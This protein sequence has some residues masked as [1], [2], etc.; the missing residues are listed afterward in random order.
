M[1]L[2]I[3]NML[4][5]L[6]LVVVLGCH[7][8]PPAPDD[9][10][11]YGY[12]TILVTD[13]SDYAVT[14]ARVQ[15]RKIGMVWYIGDTTNPWGLTH[16]Y[17][18]SGDTTTG[19]EVDTRKPGYVPQMDTFYL[20]RT[21]PQLMHVVLPEESGYAE[22]TLTFH[23]CDTT[24]NGVPLASLTS[25][26]YPGPNWPS[27]WVLSNDADS[28]GTILNNIYIIDTAR[29]FIIASAW[30]AGYE[31]FNETFWLS[32]SSSQEIYITLKTK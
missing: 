1:K 32:D 10:E 14:G 21:Q 8:N 20:E 11:I 2:F 23:I 15:I 22:K 4:L 24:G 26:W 9:D 6:A 5:A 19:I 12:F 13:T 29:D 7:D 3:G 28:S 27:L 30:K 18:F 17:S 25:L 16:E 31:E